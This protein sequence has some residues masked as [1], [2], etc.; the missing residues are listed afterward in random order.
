MSFNVVA[1]QSPEK[2]IIRVGYNLDAKQVSSSNADDSLN[3]LNYKIT[4]GKWIEAL[5]VT[6]VDAKTVELAVSDMVYD[7]SYT[8]V[9]SNVLSTLGSSLV[10]SSL[11]LSKLVWIDTITVTDSNTIVITFKI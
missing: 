10:V 1:M 8:V 4:G 5:S 6:T 11:S 7:T 2:N 3:I 9:V